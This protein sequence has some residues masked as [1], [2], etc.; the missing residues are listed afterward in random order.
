MTVEELVM[1]SF[2]VIT[3]LGRVVVLVTVMVDTLESAADMLQSFPWVRYK[4]TPV[5]GVCCYRF[6][7]SM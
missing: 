2:L 6:E 4:I 5:L 1:C 3:T 7:G